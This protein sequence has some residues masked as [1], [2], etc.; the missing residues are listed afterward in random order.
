MRYAIGVDYALTRLQARY[1]QLLPTRDWQRLQRIENFA[2]FV[3]QAR[4][5]TLRAWVLHFGPQMDVHRIETVLRDT[6]VQ[7][8]AEVAGWLPRAQR[9]ACAWLSELVR[10]P[11][12]RHLAANDTVY[13]WLP[14]PPA[15]AAMP[16]SGDGAWLLQRWSQ[17]WRARWPHELAHAE[18]QQLE[19]M[20]VAWG[21]AR[22]RLADPSVQSDVGDELEIRLRRGFR[23]YRGS[24]FGA[25]TY[26]GLLWLQT[27]RLRGALVRRRIGAPSR[28]AVA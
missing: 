11:M 1:A 25:C 9:A 18:R 13:A 28:V 7:H 23:R 3:Q 8:V 2:A 27:A 21:R 14:P 10:L 19:R 5:T 20:A 24:L 15:H 4:E 12:L 6:Y 26:L 22:Q 16:V 17:Q